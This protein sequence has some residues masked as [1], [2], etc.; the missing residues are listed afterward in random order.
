MEYPKNEQAA[1]VFMDPQ[2]FAWADEPG[3]PGVRR[4]LLGVFSARKT[5]ISVLG[6]DAGAVATLAPHAIAFVFSGRGTAGDREWRPHATLRTG[7]Q[8]EA[9]RAS[10]ASEVLEIHI[11]HLNLA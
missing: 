2:E 10:E 5:R 8:A 9:I 4:K 1:P 3:V 6:L 11:P 7:E